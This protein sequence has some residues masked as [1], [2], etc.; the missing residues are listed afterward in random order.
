MSKKEASAS[1]L[2]KRVL[3][4]I[5][6]HVTLLENQIEEYLN[7]DKDAEENEGKK[8]PK[9]PEY[10]SLNLTSYLKSLTNYQ[11]AEDDGIGKQ[12]KELQKMSKEQLLKMKEEF[13]KGNK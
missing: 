11:E 4:L 7:F 1:E 10:L 9:F 12:L 13:D 6:Q 2:Q 3:V 8:A 5:D